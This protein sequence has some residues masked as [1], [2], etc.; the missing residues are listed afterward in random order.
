[1]SLQYHILT[2]KLSTLLCH[3]DITYMTYQT[4]SQHI[5]HYCMS[6]IDSRA[7]RGCN[8]EEDILISRIC[9]LTISHISVYHWFI[10]YVLSHPPKIFL[11]HSLIKNFLSSSPTFLC[12]T[13]W[14]NIFSN[15]I[16]N[17]QHINECGHTCHQRSHP[18]LWT[19]TTKG[20]D[21]SGNP[22]ASTPTSQS[23][24]PSTTSATRS[25]ATLWKLVG[26]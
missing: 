16:H 24:R 8:R 22:T 25:H 1:M 5:L 9:P 21:E 10:L 20:S 15:R 6:L 18:C 23:L 19:P 3:W 7:S 12:I 4:Y 26:T 13:D 2:L 17:T 14:W 11:S